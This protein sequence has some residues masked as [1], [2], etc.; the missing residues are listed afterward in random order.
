MLESLCLPLK[1][2]VLPVKDE[3]TIKRNAVVEPRISI[4]LQDIQHTQY[5]AQAQP[6]QTATVFFLPDA[7]LVALLVLERK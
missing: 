3:Q 4:V 7:W 1:D 6:T 5:K 2:A